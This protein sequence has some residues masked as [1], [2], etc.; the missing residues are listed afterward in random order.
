MCLKRILAFCGLPVLANG[1][2]IMPFLDDGV[3][4][5]RVK[6]VVIAGLLVCL[7]LNGAAQAEVKDI[8]IMSSLRPLSFIVEAVATGSPGDDQIHL[9]T[10]LPAG[11]T[12][13]DYSLRPSDVS[14][15]MNAD[16]VVWLGPDVEPYLKKLLIKKQ[17]IQP[18]ARVINIL[19]VSGLEL[20]PFREQ[21]DFGD[22]DHDHEGPEHGSERVDPHIW[23]RA[24]NAVVISNYLVKELVR[25]SPDGK[26]RFGKNAATLEQTLKN[27]LTAAKKALNETPGSNFL[28][29]HDAFHYLER[30]L[31]AHSVGAVRLNPMLQPSVK[32]VLALGKLI[33]EKEVGCVLTDPAFSTAIVRKLIGDK[34]IRV[35]ELDPLGW[36][37]A[38]GR[39]AYVRFWGRLA[40]GIFNC[41]TGR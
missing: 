36:D 17:K 19:D 34:Q 8:N 13:H 7:M 27:E 21:E 5:N 35:V 12:P 10:L 1:Y 14:R 39:E 29:I 20:L 31:G 28:T 40:N 6:N 38:P 30:D 41:V 23:L 37:V 26:A 2:D 25:M 18:D 22:H 4:F 15:I 11:V 9:H 32:W 33:Q 24:Q 16:L 3:R